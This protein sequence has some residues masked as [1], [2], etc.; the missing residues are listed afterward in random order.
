M[1][2]DLMLDCAWA[3]LGIH[4]ERKKKQ[5]EDGGVDRTGVDP[6]EGGEGGLEGGRGAGWWYIGICLRGYAESRS[7]RF[8]RITGEILC[9]RVKS[10][11]G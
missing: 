8:L 11:W 2:L 5:R 4:R 3:E 6:R 10:C 7:W 1:H 9:C